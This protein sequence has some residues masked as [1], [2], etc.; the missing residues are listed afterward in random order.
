MVRNKNR[1]LFLAWLIPS[2]SLSVMVALWTFI[3]SQYGPGGVTAKAYVAIVIHS[4]E[5]GA[6]W[7]ISY[8]AIVYLV[9]KRLGGFNT[10]FVLIA[11]LVP[12]FGFSLAASD[13]YDDLIGTMPWII[14]AAVMAL[15]SWF[16]ASD[17]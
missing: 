14:Y 6:V 8:G 11:Y 4:F 1:A 7:Q 17:A 9:L 3:T 10:W 5:V 15:T 16:F 12:I 2:L 13:T